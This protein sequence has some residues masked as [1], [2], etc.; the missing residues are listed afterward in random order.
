MTRLQRAALLAFCTHIVAG[1][2]LA[3]VLRH[4]LETNPDLQDRL[5]FLVNHRALWTLAWLPW[6]ISAVAILYFYM[7]FAEVHGLK[8]SLPI[9][10]TVIALAPDLAAEAIEIGVLPQVAADALSHNAPFELFMTLHRIAVMLSGYLA[11]GLYSATATILAWF[12]RR[13]Y[14]TWLSAAGISIGILGGAASIAALL[15]S[16]TGLFSTNALLVPCILL[17]LG[18]VAKYRVKE[19]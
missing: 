2:T 8:S 17:W 7:T 16:V 1:L 18:G 6:T 9:F 10:L 5:A 14:P 15:D 3:L 12:A 4:G 11:N 13:A 19:L